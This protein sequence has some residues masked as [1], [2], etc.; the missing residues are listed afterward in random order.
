MSESKGKIHGQLAAIMADAKA[1]GKG[2]RN[3]QQGFNFR[4][5]D[6]VM[7]HLHPLFAKYGVVILPEVLAERHEER[8]TKSGGN[9]IYRI[10]TVRFTFAADDG[11]TASATVVGEGMDSGDKAANKA[12]A[13]ALKY[14]L[15]QMLL[16]PYDEVDPDGDTPPPSTPKGGTP[17]ADKPVPPPPGPR[18]DAEPGAARTIEI[19]LGEVKTK[20]S[21][22]AK[23][24]WTRFYSK[25]DDGQFYSTLDKTLGQ[26]MSRFAAAGDP[27]LL[28]FV[29]K[30]TAKGT[31]R[32][33]QAIEAAP[34]PDAD[35]NAAADEAAGENMAAGSKELPF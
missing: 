34:A 5:I 15:T 7:N 23:G 9:L 10:L 8:Q 20:T 30:T 33:V 26:A 21:A 27:V 13:V 18:H 12:M 29:E 11:S 19:T 25:A 24:T 28:T 3:Q 17:P 22:G 1:I 35:P 2:G 16:L 14:A 6:A 4:G 31:I 32:D